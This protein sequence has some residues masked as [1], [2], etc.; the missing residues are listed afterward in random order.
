MRALE[1]ELASLRAANAALTDRLA[2]LETA[3]VEDTPEQPTGETRRGMLKLL[4]GAA[5]GAVA[6][7]VIAGQPAA[8][9]SGCHC[10]PIT[11]AASSCSTAWTTPSAVA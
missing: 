9:S 2:R 8:V 6:A 5:G 7:T 10:T 3:L 1:A 11:H 4:A